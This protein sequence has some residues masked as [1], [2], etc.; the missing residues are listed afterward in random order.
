MPF[1]IKQNGRRGY[2]VS[3]CPVKPEVK[4]TLSFSDAL[5]KLR[6]HTVAGWRDYSPGS[7]RGA[8]QAVGWVTEAEAEASNLLAEKDD[9]K[10]VALFKSLSDAVE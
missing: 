7:T 2:K 1:N 4:Y 3:E 8:R 9:A 6:G 10:R 5:E